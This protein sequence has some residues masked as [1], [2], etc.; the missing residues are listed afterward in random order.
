MTTSFVTPLAITDVFRLQYRG[1]PGGSPV[2]SND[3]GGISFDRCLR[4]WIRWPVIQEFGGSAGI[5][6]VQPGEQCGNIKGRLHDWRDIDLRF[7]SPS[8]FKIVHNIAGKRSFTIGIQ[9]ARQI[10]VMPFFEGRMC[11]SHF[12]IF[13]C[14]IGPAKTIVGDGN[15]AVGLGIVGLATDDFTKTVKGKAILPVSD[16]EMALLHRSG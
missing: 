5:L 14:Q 7:L 4:C 16:Q 10:A 12:K 15:G 1:R 11:Q 8:D 2:I 3:D 6:A 9:M 13:A